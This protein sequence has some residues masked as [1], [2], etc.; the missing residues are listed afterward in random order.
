MGPPTG[1]TVDRLIAVALRFL[2]RRRAARV[3]PRAQPVAAPRRLD[4]PPPDAPTGDPPSGGSSLDDGVRDICRLDPKFNPARFVGYIESMFRR[5]H[6][7]RM[8]RDV[9]ALRDRVTPELHGALRAESDRW[10]SL[11]H[12]SHTDEIEIRAEV[13]EAWHETGRDY[14]TAFIDGSMLAYTVDE[15]TGAL[16]GGSKTTPEKV[17]AFWT[18]TRPG[19]LNPWMLSAIQT[20]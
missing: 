2:R 13:T 20:A 7:A 11:G 6:T 8:N 12:A 3:P 4:V 10:R 9:D 15:T 17:E 16:V 18:F 14:V 19:G 1:L 5:V